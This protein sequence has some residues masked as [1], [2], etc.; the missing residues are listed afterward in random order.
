MIIS[1]VVQV[2]LFPDSLERKVIR[3]IENGDH[4]RLVITS[5]LLWLT[6]FCFLINFMCY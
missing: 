1:F 6:F 3:H 2:G 4:V 5:I